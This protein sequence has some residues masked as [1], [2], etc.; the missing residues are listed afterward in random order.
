MFTITV[1]SSPCC[2]APSRWPSASGWTSARSTPTA[3]A[4]RGWRRTRRTPTGSSGQPGTGGYR[5]SSATSRQPG[6]DQS[7][8]SRTTIMTENRLATFETKKE[9]DCL[10][11]YIYDQYDDDSSKYAI[12][13]IFFQ[14]RLVK[15]Y[16][17]HHHPRRS[18]DV[19][20]LHGPLS[21]G[22]QSWA[23]ISRGLELAAGEPRG[24]GLRRDDRGPGRDSQRGV[25]RR[26]LLLVSVRFVWEGGDINFNVTRKLVYVLILIIMEMTVHCQC[27]ALSW[28]MYNT[29]NNSYLILHFPQRLGQSLYFLVLPILVSQ[30]HNPHAQHVFP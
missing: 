5:G 25:E 13:K 10:T 26:G 22:R 19:W 23:H 30:L 7:V 3:A 16:E 4:P 20:W 8:E 28:G 2:P 1:M 17:Y 12:G 6:I 27:S 24:P 11:K 15:W 21:M 14:I 18:E 29:R 9:S